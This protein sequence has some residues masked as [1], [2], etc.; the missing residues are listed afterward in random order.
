MRKILLAFTVVPLLS[1]GFRYAGPPTEEEILAAFVDS[2]SVSPPEVLPLVR[3]Y[4][5]A[6][7]SMPGYIMERPGRVGRTEYAEVL[8]YVE[9]ALDTDEGEENVEYWR[10]GTEVRRIPDLSD[11]RL[12]QSFYGDADTYLAQLVKGITNLSDGQVPKAALVVT[13]GIQ[14]TPGH[15][16]FTEMVG[17]IVRWLK[18]GFHFEV[19]AIR[20]DFHG[21]VYS[22]TDKVLVGQYSS[23]SRR[24]GKRPF[25][26]YVFSAEEDYGRRVVSWIEPQ[27]CAVL[28]YLNLTPGLFDSTSVELRIPGATAARQRNQICNF[29]TRS[30]VK[31]LYW[32]RG[33][34]G[35]RAGEIMADVPVVI[36]EHSRGLVKSLETGVNKNCLQLSSRAYEVQINKGTKGKRIAKYTETPHRVSLVSAVHVTAG[37]KPTSSPL[38]PA[39]QAPPDQGHPQTGAAATPAAA[40]LPQD[41]HLACSVKID[42][43][44][45]A[46]EHKNWVAYR[47]A[48]KPTADAI[49]IPSWVSEFS[50]DRDCQVA[51]FSKTLF[52][53]DFIRNV[54]LPTFVEQELAEV[55][56]AVGGKR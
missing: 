34:R 12:R 6:S 53:E 28:N 56:L 24:D 8:R 1:C 31:F 26:I 25:F 52:F 27:Q 48:L 29:N 40:T 22:E 19:I 14:S 17:N 33:R 18:K 16:D 42:E 7:G 30:F 38:P 9:M 50:T 10:F 43:I 20:S 55:Y 36:K 23:T 49:N 15:E 44:A 32:G 4:V 11:A 47:I 35:F 39:A 45:A 21:P 13:D 41:V 2:I 54:M 46:T 37:A 51:D 5:D 3:V